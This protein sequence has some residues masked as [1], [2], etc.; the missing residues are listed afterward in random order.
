MTEEHEEDRETSQP[1]ERKAVPE[2]RDLAVA[3]RCGRLYRNRA[4]FHRQSSGIEPAF[5]ATGASLAHVNPR[6]G[7]EAR[8][9]GREGP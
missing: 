8:V 4:G 9:A 7:L 2:H 3:C 6:L 5:S 1:V